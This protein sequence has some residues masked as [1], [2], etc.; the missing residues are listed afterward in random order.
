LYPPVWEETAYREAEFGLPY[1][2][3]H[4]S[5]PKLS[6]ALKTLPVYFEGLISNFTLA[7]RVPAGIQYNSSLTGYVDPPSFDTEAVLT[8]AG[9]AVNLAGVYDHAFTRTI[10][11]AASLTSVAVEL[12]R[13]G[14]EQIPNVSKFLLSINHCWWIQ[15]NVISETAPLNWDQIQNAYEWEAY[16]RPIQELSAQVYDRYG[17]SGYQGRHLVRHRIELPAVQG[18]QM[19]RYYYDSPQGGPGSGGSGGGGV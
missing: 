17:P 5:G 12:Y 6:S 15:N 3:L 11:A 7:T 14:F 1:V 4:D 19:R 2:L 9:N 8:I 13:S 18:T 10:A 16:L